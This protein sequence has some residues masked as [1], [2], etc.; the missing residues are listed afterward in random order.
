MRINL[1]PEEYRPQPVINPFRLT[2]LITCSVLVFTGVIWLLVQNFQLRTEKQLLASVN[3]QVDSYQEVLR[4][5][6]RY[7]KRLQSLKQRLAEVDQIKT[8]YFQYPLVLKR[9]AGTLERDMW[10]NRLDMPAL[11]QFT[12]NGKSLVFPDIGRLLQ[13]LQNL[14]E[15]AEVKLTQVTTDTDSEFELYNFL[16]KLKPKGGVAEDA[17]VQ[18]E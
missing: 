4:E 11:E 14:P 3:Q 16:I 7:E 18:K 5:I 6:S 13:N 10:L 2:V 17:K 15:L 9:L 8:A 12:V 1:L